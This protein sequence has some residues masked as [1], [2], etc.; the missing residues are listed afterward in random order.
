[1]TG[2]LNPDPDNR[3][4]QEWVPLAKLRIP[5]YQRPEP[6][7][8]EKLVNNW[9]ILACGALIVSFRDDLFWNVDGQTRAKA[10]RRLGFDRLPA[11][12]LTG[13]TEREEAALFLK[14]NRD[15]KSVSPIHRHQAEAIAGE[16]RAIAIDDVMTQQGLVV[17]N[18][19]RDRL[20]PFHAIVAAEKVFDEGGP[21]LLERV[22]VVLGLA[23]EG[24][25]SRYRGALVNGLGFFLARD[26][27]GADDNE[28]LKYLGKVK[29]A[30]LDELATHW[31]AIAGAKSPGSGAPIYMARGIAT[32]VYP[33]KAGE[34]QPKRK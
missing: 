30:R 31:Q 10:A 32:V 26:P 19:S 14:L 18:G 24:D 27:W 9:D 11:V 33:K 21:E 22:L 2:F 29:T 23:F 16:Q 25:R 34:W 6:M 15:R 20:E 3:L 7:N 17:A 4:K 5:S 1:M 12:V 8:I 13:L 28:V